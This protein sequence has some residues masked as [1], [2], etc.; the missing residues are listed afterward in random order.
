MPSTRIY[1]QQR[2]EP[3]FHNDNAVVI[4]CIAASDGANIPGCVVGDRRLSV[5]SSLKLAGLG[6]RLR[7]IIFR[8]SWLLASEEKH[9]FPLRHLARACCTP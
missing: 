6:D 4:G 3:V 7:P 9:Q 2:V 1:Y 5:R 8:A